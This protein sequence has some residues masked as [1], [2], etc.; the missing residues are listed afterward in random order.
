MFPL[1]SSTRY[2]AAAA[3]EVRWTVG[4][5]VIGLRLH[6]FDLKGS[7]VKEGKLLCTR[8]AWTLSSLTVPGMCWAGLRW[9]VVGLDDV[10]GWVSLV[11]DRW[12]EDLRKGRPD[13]L[14]RTR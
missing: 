13:R 6:G 8:H 1:D 10:G 14:P 2:V 7:R 9:S 3:D 11:L 12:V 4:A 5:C